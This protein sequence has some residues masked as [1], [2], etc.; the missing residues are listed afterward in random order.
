MQSFMASNA[1]CLGAG[2][3]IVF[4]I[5]SSA[6]NNIS[7]FIVFILSLKARLI[8]V[9]FLTAMLAIILIIAALEAFSTLMTTFAT[10]SVLLAMLMHAERILFF[11]F[12]YFSIR[13]I[14]AAMQS[15][16]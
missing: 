11:A 13:L 16:L 10:A 4:A 2:F 14:T 12:H 9:A 8:G 6:A 3:C 5:K 15:I 7:L 1:R